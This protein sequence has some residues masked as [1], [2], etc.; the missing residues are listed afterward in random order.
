MK[1]LLDMSVAVALEKMEDR[2]GAVDVDEVVSIL[3]SDEIDPTALKH[4]VKN[5]DECDT[6]MSEIIAQ[7]NKKR[8]Y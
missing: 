6:V 1:R 7:Q 2:T 5:S 3:H 4:T 8:G